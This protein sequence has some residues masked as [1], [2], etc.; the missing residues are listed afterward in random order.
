MP[1]C[2]KVLAMVKSTP[3]HRPPVIRSPRLWLSSVPQK[4]SG[5]PESLSITAMQGTRKNAPKKERMPL[6]LNGPSKSAPT[7]WAT[8]AVPQINEHNNSITMP[9][10]LLVCC[11]LKPL[12]A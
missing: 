10:K 12:A 8:N 11:M 2:C 3:Q 5:L 1:V 7:L 4:E 9:L 6:K